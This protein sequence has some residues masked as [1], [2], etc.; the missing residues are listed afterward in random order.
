M[1][2]AEEGAE[3]TTS[4]DTSHR[5]LVRFGP[6]FLDCSGV[7]NRESSRIPHP[8]STGIES[9]HQ[10]MSLLSEVLEDSRGEIQQDITLAR[11]EGADRRLEALNLV[12]YKLDRLR[13][14]VGA[15]RRILNDLRTLRR[16]LLGERGGESLVAVKKEHVT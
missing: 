9:A 7:A 10:Y 13:H 2:T 16:L 4:L 8:I 1:T 15:S 11:A 12:S 3:R 6:M 5:D 14:H